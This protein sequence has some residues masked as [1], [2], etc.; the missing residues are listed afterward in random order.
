M[1]GMLTTF[2]FRI[3]TLK[4]EDTKFET[5]RNTSLATHRTS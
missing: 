5:S 2:G 1:Q 4:D 3:P